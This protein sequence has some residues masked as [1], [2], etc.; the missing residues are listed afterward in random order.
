MSQEKRLGSLTK[1][2]AKARSILIA[3]DVASR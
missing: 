1:F 2:R 3:T